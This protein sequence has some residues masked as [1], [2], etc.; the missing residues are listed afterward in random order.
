MTGIPM[1][2]SSTLGLI[3]DRVLTFESNPQFVEMNGATLYENVHKICDMPSE[4]STNIC[5]AL[6]TIL[7]NMKD[8]IP[9]RLIIVSDMQLNKA[10]S[11]Y[12]ENTHETMKKMFEDA[13]FKLPQIVFWN[14]N[15]NQLQ[16]D[17]MYGVSIVSGFSVDVLKCL[18]DGNLPTP[19]NTMMNAL[20]D[21]KFDNIKEVI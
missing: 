19:F 9:E 15:R 13:G 1:V 10:D 8:A 4:K 12:N 2:I 16:F 11:L 3:S 7:D 20:S 5:G 18:L 14:V 21:A 6:K 17:N